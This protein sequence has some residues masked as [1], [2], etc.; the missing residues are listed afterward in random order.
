VRRTVEAAERGEGNMILLHDSGGDRTQTIA[1]I[2]GIVE[3]LHKRGFEFV[4]IAQLLGRSRDEVMP[5]V[6][7]DSAVAHL[8]GRRRVRRSQLVWR[9][10]PLAVPARHRAGY[11]ALAVRWRARPVPA[12][13]AAPSRFDPAYAPTVAVV[14][15]A[16]NEEKVIVQTIASLLACDIPG[17]LRNHR[18][19]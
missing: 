9:D 13:A 6:P 1:A 5:P 18:R 17:P 10:H 8:A 11:C 16:Y 19:R 12:L 14:I 2:P 3:E 7:P 15:P 4:T